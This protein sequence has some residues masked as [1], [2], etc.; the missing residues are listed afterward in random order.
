MSEE[1]FAP[2][3]GAEMSSEPM[4]TEIGSGAI[5]EA[6]IEDS[7]LAQEASGADVDALA[8]NL[9]AAVD[10]G[11]TDAEIKE[12][13][14]TFKI[15]VNGQEREV[16][17]DWNNKEDIVRRLQMA[18]AGQSAM[19]RSAELERNFEQSL[20]S[21]HDD[22]WEMLK[23]LGLD[24]D[25]LAEKRIQDKIAELQKSPE[26]LAAEGRDKELE[27]L[28][29]KLRDQEE[30]KDEVEFQ[31]LQEQ[32]EVDLDKQITDALSSTTEL[33]KS[34]YVVKRIADAMLMAMQNGRDDVVAADVI[35]WV[36][37]EINQEMQDLFGAMPDKMLE[38]YLGNKTIDRLRQ[39][40][41][42]K[43][44]SQPVKSIKDTGAQAPS[45]A[46][47]KKAIKLGDW[48]K[49]GSSIKDFE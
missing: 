1:N 9:E 19:Q 36:E 28:R 8:E 41:L 44:K 46:A 49:H 33:P 17:L 25:E 11:A 40:R 15:K 29:Q 22:P 47:A 39:G 7:G 37:K 34:P 5:E 24:P 31:R 35:P 26:Q 6:A 12:M 30:Q 27:E 18:E 4:S 43:M 32:A 45:E 16:E 10:A 13:I 42:A 48:L 3:A 38:S 2:D 21:L 23:E 20:Q 14:E